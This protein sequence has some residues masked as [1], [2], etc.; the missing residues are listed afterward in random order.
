[1]SPRC[2]LAGTSRQEALRAMRGV[3]EIARRLRDTQ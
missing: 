3:T 1:V 2:G